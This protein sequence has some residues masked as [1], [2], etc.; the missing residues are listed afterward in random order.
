MMPQTVSLQTLTSLSFW[1]VLFQYQAIKEKEN[2]ESAKH[3]CKTHT[4]SAEN[5]LYFLLPNT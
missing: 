3:A 1:Y 4:V 5:S 2:K